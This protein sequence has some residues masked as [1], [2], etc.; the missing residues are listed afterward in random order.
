MILYCL[1]IS[2]T[3]FQ[4]RFAPQCS[5]L[6]RRFSFLC[7]YALSISTIGIPMFT[8]TLILLIIILV[9]APIHRLVVL[10]R[11][12]GPC[13]SL[14]YPRTVPSA[15]PL[16]S[17]VLRPPPVSCR[18]TVTTTTP[19]CW[20]VS[21]PLPPLFTVCPH[22]C[23]LRP[24]NPQQAFSDDPTL[25]SAPAGDEQAEHLARGTHLL[26]PSARLQP[27]HDADGDGRFR[28]PPDDLQ[29]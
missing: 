2:H 6:S 28:D 22:P 8:V 16:P 21:R 19:L 17:P 24:E 5:A 10:F 3:K 20:A 13:V 27:V 18:I 12:A 11:P 25:S 23:T 15:P 1:L 4:S 14:S 26:P 9:L 29:R 7:F